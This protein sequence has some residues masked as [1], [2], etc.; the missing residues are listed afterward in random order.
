MAECLVSLASDH[1]LS[2]LGGLYSPKKPCLCPD[3]YE[4]EAF[5]KCQIDNL[6]IYLGF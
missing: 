5:I 1:R 3:K 2:Y 6:F 4:Y